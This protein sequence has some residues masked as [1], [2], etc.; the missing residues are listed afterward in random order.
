MS[1]PNSLHPTSRK[2]TTKNLKANETK[3][4]TKTFHFTVR[5]HSQTQGNSKN[6]HDK[7]H[8]QLELLDTS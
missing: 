7:S 5:F 1:K 2:T 3:F 6:S 4:N 8:Y